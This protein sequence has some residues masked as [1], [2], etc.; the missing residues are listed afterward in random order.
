[1]SNFLGSL[2]GRKEGGDEDENCYEE[3]DLAEE[4]AIAQLYQLNNN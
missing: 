1:L 2:F 3:E 4:E